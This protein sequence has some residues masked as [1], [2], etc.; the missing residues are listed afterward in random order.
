MTKKIT[1]KKAGVNVEQAN[2][3]VKTISAITQSTNRKEVLGTLGGFSGFFK[4]PANVKNPVMV[5]STDGVGTKL[6]IANLQ[7]RY[8][9][10]GIDLVAMC[11]NDLIT[12][13]AEPLFFLDY[14][15]TGALDTKKS[16]AIVKG[17]AK[18]CKQ[19]SCSLIGGETAE[20]PGLYQKDDY[21]LAGFSVGVVDQKKIITGKK[22]A[23]GHKAIGLLSSGIHSNGYSLARKLFTKKEMQGAWGKKLLTPTIIYVDPIMKLVKAGILQSAS[24]ITGG[25]FEDNIPRSMPANRNVMIDRSTWTIPEIFNEMQKRA[26]ISDE[27]MFRTFNMGIGMVI[28]VAPKDEN[29]ALTIIKTCNYKAATIGTVT[30]GTGIVTYK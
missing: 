8:D 12:C 24:H 16:V 11:V 15:A 4:V 1:Y 18:G 30:K 2:R 26:H 22:V 14:F 13:G 20:M 3:F 29:K 25:G 5:A 23:I 17:I 7:K 28:F 27:E 9:T 10:I 21:D 6:L 19:A